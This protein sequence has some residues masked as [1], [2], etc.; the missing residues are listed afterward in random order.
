[1]KDSFCEKERK[2]YEKLNKFQLA[3]RYKKVGTIVVIVTAIAMI[4]KG[5]VSE[6][7]WVKPLLQNFM[8]LGFLLISL[9]KERVEDELMETLRAQSYRLAFVIG[10]VYSLVQPYIEYGVEYL[11]KEEASISFNYFQVLTFMLI[12]QIMFFEQSKRWN[13]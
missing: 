7:A 8:I 3:H 2:R 11:L 5:I 4:L 6:P 9:S 1:M 12:V 10:V 13:S